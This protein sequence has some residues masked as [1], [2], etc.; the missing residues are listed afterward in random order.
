METVCDVLQKPAP[1]AERGWR[2]LCI[3]LEEQTIVPEEPI[4]RP[5]ARLELAVEPHAPDREDEVEDQSH[6][7]LCS[8]SKQRDPGDAGCT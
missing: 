1:E 7:P 5:A 6:I 8:H 4:M 3:S 2:Y